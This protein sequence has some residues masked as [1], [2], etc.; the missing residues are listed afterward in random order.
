MGMKLKEFLKGLLATVV[1]MA[2]AVGVVLYFQPKAHGA[3]L[4]APA[5]G[6][7]PAV[8]VAKLE[9]M[10]EGGVISGQRAMDSILVMCFGYVG[11]VDALEANNPVQLN[12]DEFAELTWVMTRTTIHAKRNYE[13]KYPNTEQTLLAGHR[14]A[15]ALKDNQ[16]E[17]DKNMGSC[18]TVLMQYTPIQTI[19]AREK[20]V[21]VAMKTDTENI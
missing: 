12:D 3:E 18:V 1:I 8:H 21:F 6:D 11:N 7:T 20:E 9:K 10:V 19:W 13:G 4:L 14:Q 5:E 15:A 17:Y 2:I 16:V